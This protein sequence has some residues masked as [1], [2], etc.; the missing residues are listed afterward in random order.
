MQKWAIVVL[1]M[2]GL[3]AGLYWQTESLGKYKAREKQYVA[4]I[5]QLVEAERQQ[6]ERAL[7]NYQQQAN[8]RKQLQTITHE[9]NELR[10]QLEALGGCFD[11]P[12]GVYGAERLQQSR[13]DH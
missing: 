8:V 9:S 2:A 11:Q 3:A 12:I 5:E 13:G 1:V 4:T 6:R 10:K 7:R